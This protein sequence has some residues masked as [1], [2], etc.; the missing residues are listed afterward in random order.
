MSL[1]DID[2][3]EKSAQELASSVPDPSGYRILLIMP[4][5]KTKT[6]GNILLAESFAMKEQAA[7]VVAFVLKVGP[8]AYKDP[9]R[10]PNGPWCKPGDW[11]IVRSYSGTRLKIKGKEFRFVNDDTIDGTIQDPRWIER[12]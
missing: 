8:D 7:A 4:D 6:D 10:Y 5:M 9:V 12:S 11:V 3:A 2:N 1:L